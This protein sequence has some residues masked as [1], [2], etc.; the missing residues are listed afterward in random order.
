MD[1]P[2][3]VELPEN[4]VAY[5]CATKQ[6]DFLDRAFDGLTARAATLMG[7]SALAV[8]GATYLQSRMELHPWAR[9]VFTCAVFA[10]SLMTFVFSALAFRLHDYRGWPKSRETLAD[11]GRMNPE[12]AR[13][14]L[15]SDLIDAIDNN[16]TVISIKRGHVR[17]AATSAC[18]LM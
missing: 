15:T 5:E 3:I 10:S 2:E 9:W 6:F 4:D 12:E 16:E 8:T 11:Y 14:R 17:M 1:L 18:A 7:W 13:F